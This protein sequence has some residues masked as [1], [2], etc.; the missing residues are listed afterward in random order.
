MKAL[1][2]LTNSEKAKLIHQL[3]PQ[4]IEDLISFIEG[5]CFTVQEK[6][7]KGRRA[8]DNG[9]IT[10]ESWLYLAAGAQKQIASNRKKMVRQSSVF[11]SCLF[12]GYTSLFSIH[13]LVTYTAVR[14][15]PDNKF[16]K[17][18]ELFFNP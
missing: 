14:K 11:A 18:V 16:T 17:A 2:E 12:T 1:Q 6:Q 4:H 15:H 8:W 5:M 13:C 3:F 7:E 9:F 10:F